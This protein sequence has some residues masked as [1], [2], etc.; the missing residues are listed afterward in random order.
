MSAKRPKH[1]RRQCTHSG[2]RLDPWLLALCPR[3]LAETQYVIS[4][5]FHLAWM[6]GVALS[7]NFGS[8][9]VF[10][11]FAGLAASQFLG[12]HGGYLWSCRQGAALAVTGIV[13]LCGNCIEPAGRRLGKAHLFSIRKELAD[14]SMLNRL[15]KVVL[16]GVGQNGLQF[17]YPQ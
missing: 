6:V 12:V 14:H 8:Q 13:P 9:C 1:C 2:S 3:L 11:L 15:S 7:P 5:C 17:S 16:T 10:R 4:R